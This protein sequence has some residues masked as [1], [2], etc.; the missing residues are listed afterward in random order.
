MIGRESVYFGLPVGI[1]V[2]LFF[3]DIA[4]DEQPDSRK[5]NMHFHHSLPSYLDIPH[6]E[7]PML[8]YHHREPGVR[9]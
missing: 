9:L 4:N 3:S 1:S 6:R 2:V 5:G 8:V 7:D